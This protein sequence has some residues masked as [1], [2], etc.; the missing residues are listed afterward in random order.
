VEGIADFTAHTFHLSYSGSIVFAAA[1]TGSG[2]GTDVG[3]S[4]VQ[5]A[6]QVFPGTISCPG[7]S[8]TT[9]HQDTITTANGDSLSVVIFAVACETAPGSPVYHSEGIYEI[10]G[11]TGQFAGKFGQ[12]TVE[13]QDDLTTHTFSLT[14]SG[15]WA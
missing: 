6:V 4:Q 3:V 12:G 11:R 15:T 14:F 10:L 1:Y 5:G 13:G 9:Q 2:T 8:F 7:T